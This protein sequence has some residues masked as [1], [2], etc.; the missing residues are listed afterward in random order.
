MEI[1]VI[2]SDHQSKIIPGYSNMADSL[3]GES[4]YVGQLHCGE[5]ETLSDLTLATRIVVSYSTRMA[6]TL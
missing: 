5:S 3:H 4:Y 1:S 2:Y 6:Y